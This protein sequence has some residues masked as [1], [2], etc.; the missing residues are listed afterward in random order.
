MPRIKEF[1]PEQAVQRAMDLFWCQ[2]YE[3]TSLDDLCRGLGIG[4]GSFY[5]TFGSKQALYERALDRYRTQMGGGMVQMLG[6]P[7]PLLPRLRRALLAMV[8]GTGGD[9]RGCMMGN[10]AV[11]RA[12]VDPSAARCVRATFGDVERALEAAIVRARDAGEIAPKHEPAAA[13]T[14]LVTFIEGLQVMAKVETRPNALAAAVEL[15]LA[16]LG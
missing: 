15:A 9:K 6:Q 7:G 10:A 14:M 3:A 5:A 12:A 16:C 13:A 1:D 4:K 2:G 8:G 11:E